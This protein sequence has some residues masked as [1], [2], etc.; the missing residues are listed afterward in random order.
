MV[1]SS[2][3]ETP[4]SSGVLPSS[5]A[6]APIAAPWTPTLAVCLMVTAAAASAALDQLVVPSAVSGIDY[7]INFFPFANIPFIWEYFF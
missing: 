7:V 2:I 3:L 4:L 1:V 5:P 6:T